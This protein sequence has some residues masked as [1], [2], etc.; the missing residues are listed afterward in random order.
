MDDSG[1]CNFTAV[2]VCIFVE[3]NIEPVGQQLSDLL[4]AY[5]ILPKYNLTFR[6]KER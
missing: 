5:L 2:A 6:D 3:L 4:Q 1:Y